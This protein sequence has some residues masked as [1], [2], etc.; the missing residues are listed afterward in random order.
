[1]EVFK[2]PKGYPANPNPWACP[3]GKKKSSMLNILIAIY[4]INP[5]RPH[6]GG[7]HHVMLCRWTGMKGTRCP[8]K[9]A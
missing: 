7:G 9:D 3:L 1:L 4:R 6:C 8:A 2:Q 5:L